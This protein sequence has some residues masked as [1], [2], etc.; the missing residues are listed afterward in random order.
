MNKLYLII[1]VVIV[2]LVAGFMMMQGQ[3]ATIT[4]SDTGFSPQ[5]L[6]VKMGTPVTFINNSSGP[7]WVASAP[8]PQHTDYPEF[9][10]L[11]SVEKG[12]EYTFTFDKVG[13]WKYHNHMNASSFGSVTVS[14]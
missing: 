9:N 8:H 2:V 11:K 1:G 6:T 7:M 5:S 10:Q 13:T 12:G 3:T 4:Y 14:E